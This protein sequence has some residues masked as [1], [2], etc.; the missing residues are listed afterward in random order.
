MTTPAPDYGD[1][2]NFALAR[3]RASKMLSEIFKPHHFK[4]I[5]NTIDPTPNYNNFKAACQ[6]PNGPGLSDE[7]VD[8]LWNYLQYC[9]QAIYQVVP[10]AASTGW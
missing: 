1:Y 10:E 2:S 6:S 9:S 5:M 4:A 3:A 8:W 7:E